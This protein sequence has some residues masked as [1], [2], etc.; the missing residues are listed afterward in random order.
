MC[1]HGFCG[2]FIK[3]VNCFFL[4]ENAFLSKRLSLE[5]RCDVEAQL[6]SSR[7]L[8]LNEGRPGGFLVIMATFPDATPFSNLALHFHSLFCV[9]DCCNTA[10]DQRCMTRDSDSDPSPCSAG[11][12][13]G[14]AGSGLGLEGSGLE[15]NN[16][17]MH[18]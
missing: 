8:G 1:P 16:Q 17:L 7:T 14:V 5:I 3:I 18:K 2:Y 15:Y 9:L 13:L 6:S 12:G 10:D 4:A 11:L